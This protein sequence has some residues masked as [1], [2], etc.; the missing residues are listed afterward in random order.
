MLV[1]TRL[2]TKFILSAVSL[3]IISCSSFP[4]GS[5]Y[6]SRQKTIVYSKPDN[7]SPIV[8]EL[9]KES[10][11]DIITYN[12]LKSNQKGRLWHK[13]KLDDKVGYIEEDPGDKSNS[14]TQL[15]LTTNEPMYGFV[16]ASS[17]VLRKQPNTTSAAIEKLATKEIVKI[18]EEGKNPVTVNGKTG[19]WA[20][21]KT[22]NNNI[23]FVFTPYLMLNKSP[24]N[25]V[26]GED[27]ETDEKGWA[28]TTTLPK[29]IYQKKKG[30]LHP[31]ENNQI[32]ENVFYLVDSRYITKDGKV[33]FHIYKQTASQ[34]DWYSDIEVENSADCY[35]P[36]N[37]VLVSNRYAP[38][39]SQVKETDKTI[40]K[41]IDFLDQQEEFE[42]DP[43]RSQFNT[44]NSKKDKFH[45]IITSIK[46]KYDECRGCFESEDYNLV[47]VFQEKDNQF[48]KVFDAA[49]NR[50]ASFIESDKKYFITIATSPLPEGDEDP[51]TT[52]YTEYKFDGS[53][54]VFE[55]EEKRH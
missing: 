19:N 46:S 3:F 50:S 49:G 4:I 26:I 34:A 9:K 20:K 40:R 47:Y 15:F 55:S 25:F 51:S 52:T 38:L 43:E 12:Y 36:S 17:L 7:K 31:V 29:I 13:I 23:G 14:P 54:F 42:I 45:V 16:V 35:I 11:F 27:I 21:V 44:F 18:I 5:G 6:S 22:K 2:K 28:Y 37:Q 33:Y 48:K 10:N 39:Y 1:L 24:D 41:L 8:L 30:K 53:S 32:D